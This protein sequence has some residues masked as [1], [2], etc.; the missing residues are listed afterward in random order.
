MRSVEAHLSAC[1]AVCDVLPAEKTS[2]SDALG[3]V[4]SQDVRS[5]VTLPPFDNSSMDGFAVR[6]G[7]VGTVPV[8]LAVSLDVAAGAGRGTLEPGTAAR[9]MTGAP[10][11]DGTEAVV[12]VEW[13]DAYGPDGVRFGPPDNHVTINQA[14]ER[15]QNIRRAGEDVRNGDLVLSAG[16]RLD[17]RAVGLLAAVGAA[18]VET[19]RRPRVVVMS[20]GSELRPPGESLSL[21]QIYDSNSFAV[22]AAATVAGATAKRL[23][24]T[25]DDP[26]ALYTQL[27]QA[28]READLIVTT[29]GVS[30]G[31]Y[32][33]VKQLLLDTGVGFIKVAMKPGMPQGVGRFEGTPILTLP[34]NPVS[35]WV[36]WEVF[37][38]PMVRALQG[39][40]AVARP[41]VTGMVAAEGRTWHSPKGKL[42]FCRVSL[43]DG[44]IRAIGAQQ[45][46]LLADLAQANALAVI[47]EDI[48]LVEDGQQLQ[49]YP[50]E[51]F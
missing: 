22:A 29:G 43:R 33:V 23:V 32:D 2:I 37:G 15:A 6:L 12:Q 28:A 36:S 3:R 25:D 45:S 38:R 47:P 18:E 13:T 9:V 7:D 19:I 24:A 10:A 46:H 40:P 27:V 26:D 8:E 44:M 48:V 42:E 4:L 31:A 30:A 1:L 50:L 39:L 34:G 49:C 21:G 41:T 16:R 20:T 51:E 35:A 5:G 14:P 11:P 17:A